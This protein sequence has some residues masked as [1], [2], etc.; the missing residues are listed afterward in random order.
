MKDLSL[1]MIMLTLSYDT[2]EKQL[3]ENNEN[4]SHVYYSLDI[5]FCLKYRQPIFE[6][7]FLSCLGM[8]LVYS[9]VDAV[10]RQVKSI[11]TRQAPRAVV[12]F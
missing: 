10:V 2:C 11:M 3:G 8:D 4:I 7:P 5:F 12:S 9:C 1:R 6:Q